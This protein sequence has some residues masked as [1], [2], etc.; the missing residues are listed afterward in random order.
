MDERYHL[1]NIYLLYVDRRGERSPLVEKQ[2]GVGSSATLSLDD[3]RNE[4]DSYKCLFGQKVNPLINKLYA[5]LMGS[6]K[7]KPFGECGDEFVGLGFL[8]AATMKAVNLYG[9]DRTTPLALFASE[10]DRL[11]V[12]DVERGLW[13][14]A[15]PSGLSGS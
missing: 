4:P 8:K 13:N 2:I 9:A 6:L 11:D 15:N 7:G 10:F 5:T 1:R 14:L 12:D 3:R